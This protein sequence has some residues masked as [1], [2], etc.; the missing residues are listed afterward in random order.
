MGNQ[1]YSHDATRVACEIVW[2]DEIGDVQRSACLDRAG[3]IGRRRCR[4]WRRR[5]RYP[6]RSTGICGWAERQTG[7]LPQATTTTWP[8]LS[9]QRNGNA[10]VIAQARALSPREGFY[11]PF[12]WRGFYDFGSSLIGDWGIHILGPANWA[13]QL[14]PE[15]LISVECIKK[16]AQPAFTF[17]D[18]DD[19]Q[20]RVRSTA[21]RDAAGDRAIGISTQAATPGCRQA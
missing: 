16:D 15:Y 21:G 13:L 6:K 18:R 7:R 10:T 14:A 17:P 8:N 9:W 4:A 20:I 19:D 5:R 1:G 3:R 11:L 12:N 2:S